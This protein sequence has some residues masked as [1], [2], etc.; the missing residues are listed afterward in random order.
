MMLKKST[1]RGL[2]LGCCLI[3]L[4]AAT[5][6]LT[7]SGQSNANYT[8][9]PPFLGNAVPPNILFIV[10]LSEAMLPAAYGSYPLSYDPASGVVYAS[11]YNGT[12]F[13]VTDPND[14]F[15]ANNTYFG[16]FDSLG[17]YTA[18]NS[19]FASRTPKSLVTDSCANTQWDGNFLNWLAMRK[20]DLAKKVLIGG[21][22]VSAS[23]TDGTAN[24]LLG[25]P[26]TGQAGSTNTCNSTSKSCYRYVKFVPSSLLA[27]R[28]PSSLAADTASFS[29]GSEAPGTIS[30]LSASVT[31]VGTRFITQFQAGDSFK[32]GAVT[33]TVQSVT[34]D[35][36]LTL[37]SAFVSNL[38]TGTV[39]YGPGR[40]IGSGEGN[41]Y[42][43]DDATADPFCNGCKYPIQV[44]LTTES[45]E[46][47]QAQSLGLL[48][49]MSTANKR[50]G[51]MFTNSSNGVAATVFRPF[52]GNFNASAI[53]GI[54][55]QPL[56]SYA[57]LAEGTYEGF[58]YYRNS[59]GPCFNNNPADFSSSV[60]AQGDPYYFT[61]MKQF[62][63]C[64]KSFIVMI[65]SGQPSQ[66]ANNNPTPAPFGNLFSGSDTIGLSSSRLDDVALY[67]QTHDIRDQPTGTLGALSGTQNV[68]FYAVNAMG[69]AAGAGVLASAAKFGGFI[70]QDRN[71]LPNATG[72]SCT[73]PASS[74]LGSG[75][76]TSSPE[77]D[78]D[79]D[80]VPDTYFDASGG[81]D[82]EAQINNAIVSI[83][84]RAASGTSSS[85]L[86]S[87]T[88][89]EGAMYQA[90]FFPAVSKV[91]GT[92]ESTVTWTGY[93]QG[94]FVD[95]FGN[96]REDYSGPG[97]TGPPD[98]KLVLNHDCIVK[99]RL[100]PASNAV[101]VDRYKDDNADGVAD[102][103][104]PFQTVTLR[105]IQPIWEAGARLALL[106]PG[107]TCPADTGGVTCRRLLTWVDLNNDGL[108]GANEQTEFTANTAAD[109]AK[110]CPYLGNVKTSDGLGNNPSGTMCSLTTVANQ[111]ASQSA[112]AD[113]INFIRGRQNANLR[114]RQLPLKDD[115]GA[116]T[117]KVWKLGD[118]I[119]STPVVVGA[120][121]ERYDVLYGDATYSAFF[122]RYK[123]R[124]QVSYVG[125]NDGMLHAFNA[126]FY[127]PGDDSS[128][129]DV[130]EHVRFTTTPKQPGTST[131]CDTLPCDGSVA[132]YAYRSNNPKLGAELWGF[133]PQDLLPHLQWLTNADYAHVYYVDL[134]PKITDARIF[135]ADA[136]HPGGWGTILIGGFR[137]GGSCRNCQSEGLPFTVAAPFGEFVGGV[138]VGQKSRVFLSSYFV[139]DIT[140]PEKDPVLLWT[141]RDMD[142]GFTTSVPAVVRVNPVGDAKTSSANEKWYAVFGTGPTGYQGV[143]D[144]SAKLFVIDLKLGPT[145]SAVNQSTGTVNGH[146]CS[147]LQ[148]CIAVGGGAGGQVK[149]FDTG[150]QISFVGDVA[151]VDM[152]L[153]FKVDVI[154]AGSVI[155]N[156]V[157]SAMNCN[158]STAPTWKGALYRLTTNSGNPDPST[159]GVSNAPTKL[160]SAF[161]SC[162]TS[163]C[164]I[165]PITAVPAMT[166]DPDNNLWLFA[167][168]GRFYSTDDASNTDLQYYFGIKDSFMTQGAPAQTSERNNLFD[169]SNVTICTSCASSANVSYGTGSYSKGFDS[170]AN[171]LVGNVQNVDGWFTSL[172]TAGE[173]SLSSTVVLGG[174]LFFTTAVPSTDMCAG[175]G[176]GYVYGLY[177]LT[178][179]AYTASAMGVTTIGVNTIG[180]RAMSLGTGLP[181]NMALQIGAAGTGQAGA[182]TGVGCTGRLTGFIQSS[183]G[184]VQ[185]LCSPGSSQPVWSRMLSWRDM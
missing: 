102:T 100:D 16:I 45:T 112:A 8:A 78:V 19:Q 32:A 178:G 92:S 4:N 77:W 142:L 38:A 107:D 140:N 75:I 108:V 150:Q 50:V 129:A 168:T 143:A 40:Y 114:D 182:T 24:S 59:Q 49:N 61:S 165:G 167:G 104:I 134:K 57:A 56:S 68:T 174:S 119:S 11:N 88:T 175:S 67:G 41:L 164:S 9:V 60:G 139:L 30:A 141:F 103:S 89:G 55:N 48:Q 39:Y 51:V 173:R 34:D 13:T 144:Q 14:T 90:Y 122:R 152:D 64:C 137:M 65:S 6:P 98:G 105:E 111:A 31:G 117:T 155:C 183:T 62:V 81:S 85:V 179:T 148:P 113:I 153:D 1:M 135:A 10:D 176:T 109:V 121:R 161:A 69:G 28:A 185:Q 79:Q 71:G 97:C 2:W 87:S 36:H 125:A 130:V 162:T 147:V 172:P 132:P 157:V 123:D 54:R 124:R 70:D 158:A 149:I 29:A 101:L 136:D 83:L 63:S 106:D 84:K 170:G 80:C 52:D 72:Q 17:C 96:L 23:N 160:I 74:P 66:D 91:V 99:I 145:Y 27:G 138:Y 177:Y 76:G 26:K 126:G 37:T 21:R 180:S 46:Y 118:I 94:L 58:C 110:F 133:I 120:P 35:T 156:G 166:T 151:S 159:W 116:Q 163:S 7:A 43:N 95:K 93:L 53:T 131:N 44:D 42:V 15:V 171:N 169:V 18:T 146:T 86:A 33:K 47:R 128:T 82:L 181:S 12:G 20:I 3:A 127:T 115:S 184:A 25:E 22:T 73:Y 154:Y 5:S